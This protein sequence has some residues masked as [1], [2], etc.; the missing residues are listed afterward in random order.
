MLFLSLIHLLQE[1]ITIMSV[2]LT[3]QKLLKNTNSSCT[4]FFIFLSILEY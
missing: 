1:W 2:V 3:T 4:L